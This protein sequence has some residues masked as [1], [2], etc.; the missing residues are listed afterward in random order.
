[1]TKLDFLA[2]ISRRDLIERALKTEGGI[3]IDEPFMADQKDLIEFGL[4][5]PAE[6]DPG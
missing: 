6:I 2:D 1:M 5:E 3:V 4:G